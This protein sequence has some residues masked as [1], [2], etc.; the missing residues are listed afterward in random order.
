VLALKPDSSAKPLWDRYIAAYKH[1]GAMLDDAD[2]KAHAND[3]AGLIK[4][5]Q[6]IP[7]TYSRRGP[8]ARQLGATTCAQ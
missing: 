5:Q 1:V 6:G 2:A 8:I 4:V 3:R 7:C